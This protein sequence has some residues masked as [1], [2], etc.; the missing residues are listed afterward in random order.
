ME[1]EISYGLVMQATVTAYVQHAEVAASGSGPRASSCQ[2]TAVLQRSTGGARLG[3]APLTRVA[4]VGQ[5][6]LEPRKLAPLIR[7]THPKPARQ[8]P[9]I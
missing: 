8:G 5:K 6:F 9:A 1:K 2:M 3:T 7:V 4:T